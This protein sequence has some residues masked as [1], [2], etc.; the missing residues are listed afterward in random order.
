MNVVRQVE[1]FVDG[2]AVQ[3]PVGRTVLQAC[4]QVEGLAVPRFCYQANLK[5]A[6]NCRMCLVEIRGRPKPVASCAMPA[7]GGMQILTDRPLVRKAREGVMEFLLM[8][9]PLDCPIC[10]QGGECDLQDQRYRF[11]GDRR[12]FYHRNK[13]SV[14]DKNVGPVVHTVMTRCIHCTRCIRFLAEVVG[15]GEFAMTGRGTHREV[16]TYVQKR[17]TRG[18]RGN[19]IDLCPVGALTRKPYVFRRRR[20]EAKNVLTVD[21]VEPDMAS[22]LVEVGGDLSTRVLPGGDHWIRDRTRFSYD[23]LSSYGKVDLEDVR[24]PGIEDNARAVVIGQELSLNDLRRAVFHLEGLNVDLARLAPGIDGNRPSKWG[25]R[26]PRRAV[27]D[28]RDYLVVVGAEQFRALQVADLRKAFLRGGTVVSFGA[29][30]EEGK[31]A[32]A[33]LGGGN[34]LRDLVEFVE[35]KHRASVGLAQASCGMVLIRRDL[36]RGSRSKVSLLNA[37]VDRLERMGIVV[38]IVPSMANEVAHYMEGPIST[39]NEVEEGLVVG[40]A[41]GLEAFGPA[42]LVAQRAEV[43]DSFG[44]VVVKRRLPYRLGSSYSVRDLLALKMECKPWR[45]P[46]GERY[47]NLIFAGHQDPVDFHAAVVRDNEWLQGRDIGARAFRERRRACRQIDLN[48]Q[49]HMANHR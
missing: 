45:V 23:A 34:R 5:V 48:Q 32:L 47:D 28:D 27:T 22:V 2:N 21:T 10:D 41:A 3:V 30:I 24:L 16:G 1:V 9:H 38:N 15:R 42:P 14:L 33:F 31:A 29:L 25:Y 36:W 7:G 19:L 39:G 12:R 46:V 20:W 13:R 4:E 37:L 35:G 8:N 6:G 49:L 40:E 17:L 11:G 43:C 18:L 44:K 26:V